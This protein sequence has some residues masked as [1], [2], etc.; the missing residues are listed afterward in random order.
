MPA[1]VEGGGAA[2]QGLVLSPPLAAPP[3]GPSPAW[4]WTQGPR[5]RGCCDCEA[6]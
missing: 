2:G 4:L 5:A 1:E 3:P 6:M